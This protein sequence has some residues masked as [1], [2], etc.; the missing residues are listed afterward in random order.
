MEF[1]RIGKQNHGIWLVSEKM[2]KDS[3]QFQ[4]LI[5]SNLK[6]LLKH[7]DLTV[8]QFADL[9]GVHE[10]TVHKYVQ[11]AYRLLPERWKQFKAILSL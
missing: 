4:E 7:N 6:V 3:E 1:M 11:G 8:E 5:L 10:Q 9:L 2:D